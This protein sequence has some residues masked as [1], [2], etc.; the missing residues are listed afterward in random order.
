MK[1]HPGPYMNISPQ[2]F[3]GLLIVLLIISGVISLFTIEDRVVILIV[4]A[5]TAICSVLSYYFVL[6]S[7]LARVNSKSVLG[8][9]EKLFDNLEHSQKRESDDST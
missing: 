8:K 2:D 1:Y 7:I 6:P 5:A 4:M 9:V 3:P